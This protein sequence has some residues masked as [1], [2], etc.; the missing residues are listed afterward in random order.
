[1]CLEGWKL[2]KDQLSHIRCLT[3]TCSS[4]LLTLNKDVFLTS[5]VRYWP[6]HLPPKMILVLQCCHTRDTSVIKRG[7]SSA[8]DLEWLFCTEY[9]AALVPAAS[10]ELPWPHA[11]SLGDC[12]CTYPIKAKSDSLVTKSMQICPPMRE[13]A[14]PEIAWTKWRLSC[15]YHHFPSFCSLNVI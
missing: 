3:I 2:P 14:V 15:L 6:K 12:K 4:Q 7:R 11:I 9:H 8:T 1:M 5:H 10:L 13:A